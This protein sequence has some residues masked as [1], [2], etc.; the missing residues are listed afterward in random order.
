MQMS[1]ALYESESLLR[2]S[3]DPHEHQ[4]P[5]VYQAQGMVS[6][7]A[8]CSIQRALALMIHTAVAA[9]VTLEQVS[10]VV[11]ARVVSFDRTNA[12]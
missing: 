8:R 5:E 12:Q 10:E 6:V 1:S 7:Q 9:D 4:S 3:D 11:L 2:M